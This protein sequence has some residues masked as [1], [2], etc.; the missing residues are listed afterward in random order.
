M[1]IDDEKNEEVLDEELSDNDTEDDSII[2]E[3]D[4]R[5]NDDFDEK[6]NELK[7]ENSRL[8]EELK[9]M[10]DKYM[11]LAAEF[12]NY[13]ERNKKE[14]LQI[15]SNAM[16]DAVSSLIPIIDDIERIL[17]SFLDMEEKYSK[18]VNMILKKTHE[19]LKKLGIES[20][21]DKGDEFDPSIH[22]ASSK[23]D[24][25]GDKTVISEVYQ[26]GYKIHDKLIRP[27]MVQVSS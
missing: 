5:S 11:R 12:K 8:S 18:G 19:S 15:H 3:V 2:D 14:K 1:R 16:I 26:K 20:F 13:Q 7:S 10:N 6:F 24:G 25:D 17:P 4:E 22:N 27:A 9:V 21:G 23:I